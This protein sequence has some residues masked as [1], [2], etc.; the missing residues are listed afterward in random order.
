MSLFLVKLFSSGAPYEPPKGTM[1]AAGDRIKVLLDPDVWKRMQE[2]HGGWNELM[3][4]VSRLK[5]DV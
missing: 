4:M 2:G 5:V 1:L 3:S